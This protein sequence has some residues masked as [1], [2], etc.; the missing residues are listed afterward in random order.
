MNTSQTA[1]RKSPRLMQKGKSISFQSHSFFDINAMA[2]KTWDERNSSMDEDGFSL[3][4]RD[5][6][7]T[8]K[9]K[10]TT[11]SSEDDTVSTPTMK[12]KA[13]CKP[14]RTTSQVKANDNTTSLVAR[15]KQSTT[16]TKK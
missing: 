4:D 6:T 5:S 14:T 11:T 16:D 13:R 12:R 8:E 9:S 10:D 7:D 1:V 2:D 15:G 3:N